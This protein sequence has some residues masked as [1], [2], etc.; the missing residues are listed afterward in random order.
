LTGALIMDLLLLT[1]MNSNNFNVIL[2]NI[3][4]NKYI[5]AAN[6]FDGIESRR[7]C[8]QVRRDLNSSNSL[9]ANNNAHFDSVA[10]AA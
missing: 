10:L 4:Y 8:K 5:W 7:Q 1:L 9:V 2:K 6:G 3:V